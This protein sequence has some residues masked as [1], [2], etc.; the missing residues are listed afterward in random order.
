MTRWIGLVT[1]T[2][3]LMLGSAA[4]AQEAYPTRPIKMICGFRA[5][6]SLDV[7]SRIYAA[8][9]E[10]S[11]GQAV[12]VERRVGAAGN[13]A[14]EAVAR[15]AP[16]GYTLLTNGVSFPIAMS[17]YKKLPFHVI[18]DFTPV[19]FMGDIPLILAANERLGVA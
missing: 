6:S 12:V 11:L 19:G 16:D 8:R 7:I 1:L 13:I 15:A 3:G 9:L 4:R 10:K 2:L 17:L 5:G 14:A 18:N